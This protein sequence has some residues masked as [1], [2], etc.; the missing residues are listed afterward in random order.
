MAWSTTTDPKRFDEAA[1]W[2]LS[3]IAITKGWYEGLALKWRRYTFTAAN[4]AHLQMVQELQDSLVEAMRQGTHLR[5]W[6]RAYL[7]TLEAQWA[8]TV[9]DPGFRA[10]T[11]YRNALQRS[12]NTGRWIVHTDPAVLAVRPYWLYDAVLDGRTTRICEERHGKILPATDPWWAANYPPLHHRCRSGVRAIRAEEAEKRGVTPSPQLETEAQRGF[13]EAP[14]A[15][16]WNPDPD[17]MPAKLRQV[18]EKKMAAGTPVVP[19]L[20]PPPPPPGSPYDPA[21]QPAPAPAS[22]GPAQPGEPPLPATAGRAARGG[23]PSGPPPL[24]EQIL[25]EQVGPARGSN[26]GGLYRGRDGVTR[27][28]KVYD[29][30]AQAYGEHLANQVYR[31]LGLEAPESV[32]FELADGRTGYASRLVEDARTLGEAGLTKARA[33]AALR[34][35]AADVLTANWDAAGLNLDNLLVTKNGRLVRVDNG[36]AFLMRA[37]YGRKPTALLEQI[38]EWEG[39]L[40]PNKNPAYARL[41]AEA[42]ISDARQLGQGLIRQIDDILKL[43]Q[44]AG[45]WDAF[46]RLHAP[47]LLPDDRR[48]IVRMLEARTTLLKAKR[49]EVRAWLRA[50][51]AARKAAA[52]PPTG[53]VLDFEAAE[54][55]RHNPTTSRA[56]QERMARAA[57]AADP[58]AQR[59]VHGIV[60]PWT[61][62]YSESGYQRHLREQAVRV[63]NGQAPTTEVGRAAKRVI[64]TRAARWAA[65]ATE[66]GIDVPGS[67][68]V[69]RGVKADDSFLQDVYE[70]WRDGAET[71]AARVKEMASWSFHRRTATAFAGSQGIVYQADIPF[72]QTFADQLVDDGSF[73]NGF[74]TEHELVS[75]TPVENA[76]V[77]DARGTT[78]RFQGRTY[79]WAERAE[80][81]AAWEAKHGPGGVKTP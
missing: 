59:D 22:V 11:I 56:L 77:V 67:F 80:F 38:T 61:A 58:A 34:G 19:P 75:L 70:A 25:G 62:T 50:S 44:T 35:F 66:L 36:G 26:P 74:F 23:T 49:A 39:F 43:E 16:E 37:R 69:Y 6:K 30:A 52:T 27:Y 24:R 2:F 28:V 21:T 40:D 41:A 29:D 71:F 20:K 1:E 14:H 10:S 64:E 47:G 57:R 78:V 55:K 17:R 12:Y 60:D 76:I 65:A 68:R 31:G 13:G 72:M 32:V 46:V 73:L 45:G 3:R 9:K 48:A 51:R 81:I 54:W 53:P 5:E 15:D 7:A 33:K 18:W 4:L 42:G 63:L 79:T 8:G